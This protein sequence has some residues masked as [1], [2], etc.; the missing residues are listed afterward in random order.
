[1]LTGRAAVRPL[2]SAISSRREHTPQAPHLPKTPATTPPKHHQHPHKH[3]PTLTTETHTTYA[4]PHLPPNTTPEP[5]IYSPTQHLTPHA[6]QHI[7]KSPPRTTPTPAPTRTTCPPA[8]PTIPTPHQRPV[9]PRAPRHAPLPTVQPPTRLLPQPK[10][11]LHAFGTPPPPP[12]A[13]TT[14]TTTSTLPTAQL[15]NRSLGTPHTATSGTALRTRVSTM[16]ALVRMTPAPPAGCS[17]TR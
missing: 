11:A 16:S 3:T 8:P 7:P 4:T 15:P 6:P 10:P 1:M 2:R 12:N 5:A 13:A 14:S 9:H 17:A